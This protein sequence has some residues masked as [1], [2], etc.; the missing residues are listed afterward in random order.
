REGGSPERV[1][2]HV[3]AV[4]WLS[5]APIAAAA[6]VFAV[7]GSSITGR[8]LGAQYGGATGAELSRLVVYLAPWT[9]V[10]VALT[11]AYPLLFVRGRARWLPLAA[12]VAVLVHIPVELVGRAAFG[13]GGLAAGMAVTTALVLGALLVALGALERTATGVLAA[14]VVCGG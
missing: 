12:V 10:S 2:R 9:I 7:A 8:V 11:V 1:A 13:L 6:G 3:V 5:L 14:A 4:S